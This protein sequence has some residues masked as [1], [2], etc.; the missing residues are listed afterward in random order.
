MTKEHQLRIVSMLG[1]PAE[2]RGCELGVGTYVTMRVSRGDLW[3]TASSW[4][5]TDGDSVLAGSEDDRTEMA[6]A[7]ERFVGRELQS[8]SFERSPDIDILASGGLALRLFQDTAAADAT[9][10]SIRSERQRLYAHWGGH[11]SETGST[12]GE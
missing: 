5:I 2:I 4:L 1:L 7:L 11:V 8:V 9:P 10:V 12:D 6:A 3:V